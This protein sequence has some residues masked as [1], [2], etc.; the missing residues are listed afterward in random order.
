MV[1]FTPTPHPVM[2]APTLDEI[3]ALVNEV[4]PDEAARRL[5]LRED[6]IRA[7]KLDAY[8]H[9]YEPPTWKDADKLLIEN[10]DLLINGGN[11]AGK[12][13]YAA[14]RVCQLLASKPE[15]RVWC[16]HTTNQSSIQMQQNVIYKYLPPEF[17]TARKTKITNVGYT[18]TSS[19]PSHCTDS[20][21]SGTT[22]QLPCVHGTFQCT[23]SCPSGF[24]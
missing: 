16:L 22:S 9:G 19:P 2:I 10:R 1:D 23:A 24:R 3:K 11:R 18:Q 13:E 4:G 21:R 17:R 20:A 5:Q 15:A 7:E 6:K 12:T 14:K 8:R